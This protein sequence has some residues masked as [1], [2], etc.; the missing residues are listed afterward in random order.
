[1]ASGKLF[2]ISGPSGAGKGTLVARIAKRIP[3]SWV[4]VSA[5]T[6]NPRPREVNGVHYYFLTDEEFD[7]MVESDG[8]L[9]WANVHTAR[10]GTPRA[11]VEEHMAAGQDVLLEIDVQ[12]GLAVKEK[13]PDAHLVFIDPPSMEELRSRLERRATESSDVI[14]ARM[15]V[16]EVEIAQKMKYDFV[17]VNDNLDTATDQL[18]AYMASCAEDKKDEEA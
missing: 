9:E 12:G 13:M 18:V 2:V 1:M 14:D 15:K 16:A 8:F 5:T 7:Q 4:S 6:R 3:T 10:Y 11:S 17:L